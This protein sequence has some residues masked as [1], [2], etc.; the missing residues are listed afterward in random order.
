MKIE[1][2]PEDLDK[3]VEATKREGRWSNHYCLLAQVGMRVLNDA[4]DGCGYDH[5]RMV[6]KVRLDVAN[7][8]RSFVE[9]F[10]EAVAHIESTGKINEAAL[11]RLRSLL[12]V[13]ITPCS[14]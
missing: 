6:N 7:N 2:L 11:V 4:V 12:P 1:I 9:Q 14:D 10:D 3:A 8:C 13:D 5:V